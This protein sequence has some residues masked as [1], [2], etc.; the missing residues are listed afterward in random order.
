MENKQTAMQEL[1]E[2][3]EL[4][5][6]NKPWPYL[7]DIIKEVYL[8]KEK[9]QIVKAYSFPNTMI[10]QTSEEYYKKTYGKK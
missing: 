1:I 2:L 7:I 6:T 5:K 3:L 9:E 4:N 10:N 8:V